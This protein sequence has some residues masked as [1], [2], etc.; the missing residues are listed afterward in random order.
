MSIYMPA[1]QSRMYVCLAPMMTVTAK[2]RLTSHAH[3]KSEMVPEQF[4]TCR[5]QPFSTTL[6]TIIDNPAHVEMYQT[7][8][9]KQVEPV[10]N[11]LVVHY[12]YNGS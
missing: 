4:S 6:E 10:S 3:N 5:C 9:V 11:I 7:E 2:D 8:W 1:I 12:G